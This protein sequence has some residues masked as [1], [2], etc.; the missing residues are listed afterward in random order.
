MIGQAEA[1]V[2]FRL[3]D[4]PTDEWFM[5]IA[6]SPNE[7]GRWQVGCVLRLRQ[8][9]IEQDR[10]L[11]QARLMD[12]GGMASALSHEIKQPLFTIAL[13]AENA[14]FQV[15]E[16]TDPAS[17]AIAKK[18]TRIGEQVERARSIIDQVSN[19][20]RIESP[21]G[22]LFDPIE[23][24]T[25]S[26]AFLRP[27]LVADDMRLTIN[28]HIDGGAYVAMS[29]VGLEQV[30]VNALQNA[31]DSI[32]TRRQLGDTAVGRI[33]IDIRKAVG[34]VQITIAD[35][36]AG[37]AGEAPQKAFEAFFTTKG[38][39]KGTGLGLYVCRQIMLEAGGNLTLGSGPINRIPM[40]AR[41]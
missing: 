34:E 5:L 10:M 40:A 14:L 2:E 11:H 8:A 26:A 18:L 23:A 37:L 29:R 33:E 20:A 12:L 19:Y 39:S 22:E 7:L 28:S 27:L 25:A 35:D 41:M 1:R 6:R 24:V 31:H 16:S 3:A 36:G 4:S 9:K 38:P 21:Q 17:A 13:A 30:M 15:E 32:M